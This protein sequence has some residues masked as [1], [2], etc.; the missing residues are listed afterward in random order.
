MKPSQYTISHQKDLIILNPTSKHTQTF[1][2]LHGWGQAGD[3]WVDYFTSKDLLP[4]V[5][6]QSRTLLIV[7]RELKSFC[8]QLQ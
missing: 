1:L 3:L 8:R 2:F 7:Y 5:K 6:Q 4:E